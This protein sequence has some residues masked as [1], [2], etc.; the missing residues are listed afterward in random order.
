MT[1]HFNDSPIETAEQDTFGV[2]HFAS[3]IARSIANIKKPIGSTIAIQGSWGAGKSSAINIIRTEL[4]RDNSESICVAEFKCWWFRGDEALAL[5]FLQT[6][7]GAIAPTLGE[8]AGKTFKSLTKRLSI[9]S[10]HL[11]AHTFLRKLYRRDLIY[12]SLCN[13]I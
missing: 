9:S 3:A 6:V 4:E 13:R 12:R 8:V 10:A 5:A 11:R 1:G 7:H 2:K